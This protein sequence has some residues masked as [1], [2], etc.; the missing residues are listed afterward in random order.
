VRPPA[1]TMPVHFARL[2]PT[3]S[4]RVKSGVHTALA[5]IAETAFVHQVR[6]C[7]QCPLAAVN[8]PRH[9]AALRP[10][11]HHQAISVRPA[12]LRPACGARRAH[13]AQL[14]PRVAPSEAAHRAR[15]PRRRAL[16]DRR[17][18]ECV[19]CARPAPFCALLGSTMGWSLRL[20]ARYGAAHDDRRLW[21]IP[22]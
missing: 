7:L 12:L 9:A 6:P 2:V 17:A 8:A 16:G 18:R 4:T 3:S 21:Q 10:G 22:K 1:L 20:S 14:V 13:P 15:G 5:I 19:P 11:L